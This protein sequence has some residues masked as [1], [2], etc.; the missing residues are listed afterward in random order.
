MN[1]IRLSATQT[2]SGQGGNAARGGG[3]TK[4][5]GLTIAG[6]QGAY[7]GGGGSGA[8]SQTASGAAGGAGYLGLVMITEF[9]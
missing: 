6:N 2:L 4:G 9:F 8:S 1:G 3:N 5:V 7:W